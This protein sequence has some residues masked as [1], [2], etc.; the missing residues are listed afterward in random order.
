MY[1]LQSVGP[2][3]IVAYMYM[4]IGVYCQF[5]F[6]SLF[7]N[8]D[9]ESARL[10]FSKNLFQI[11]PKLFKKINRNFLKTNYVNKLFALSRSGEKSD[12]RLLDPNIDSDTV[13]YKILPT[14][15]WLKI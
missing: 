3:H 6:L 5:C 1:F 4:Y 9:V 2:S 7:L 15:N 14:L 11:Y 12:N 8:P 13:Q 10:T